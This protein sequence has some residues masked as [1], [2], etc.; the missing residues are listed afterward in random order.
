MDKKLNA[1]LGMARRRF[2]LA[3]ST[4]PLAAFATACGGGS[5]VEGDDVF[6]WDVK[7][8]N[9][10]ATEDTVTIAS[11]STVYFDKLA[12]GQVATRRFVEE[13]YVLRADLQV[14]GSSGFAASLAS[15]QVYPALYLVTSS[16]SAGTANT[17]SFGLRVIGGVPGD[18]NAFG[19]G[20][21]PESVIRTVTG[22]VQTADVW[23][24]Y[25]ANTAMVRVGSIANTSD[26]SV[27]LRPESSSA[28]RLQL[29]DAASG[30][31]LYDSGVR[32]KAANTS[33]LIARTAPRAS[34]WGVY[35][36]DETYQLTRWSSV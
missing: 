3:S 29:R 19:V 27:G 23:V 6:T 13:D 18:Y 16:A 14:S 12:Y 10:A 21:V 5:Q 9:L 35:A 30:N 28:F 26:S 33:M 36:I 1:Q 24:A 25:G 17:S 22:A 4:I 7:V 20:H 31:V 2:L 32:A 34:T 15:T 11:G 8:L